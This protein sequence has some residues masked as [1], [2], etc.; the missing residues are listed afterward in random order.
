MTVGL[1]VHLALF[2]THLVDS[3]SSSK[4]IRCLLNLCY[5]MLIYYYF[6]K[7]KQSSLKHTNKLLKVPF[8]QARGSFDVF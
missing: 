2:R 7:G 1:H 5:A 4:S 6:F 8:H 3:V